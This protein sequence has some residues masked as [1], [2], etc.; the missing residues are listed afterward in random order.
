MLSRFWNLFRR[1]RL[2]RELDAELRYHMESL[3][4]QHR[5]RGLSAEEARMAA[6]RD[7]GGAVAVEEGT[8]IKGEFQCS[9]ACVEISDSVCDRYG[10]RRR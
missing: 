5:H 3:E 4:A 1:K 9:R 6:R 2:D 7:F 10:E 8:A